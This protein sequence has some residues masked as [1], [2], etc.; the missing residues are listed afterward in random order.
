MNTK[1]FSI[2]TVLSLFSL[3]FSQPVM[4]AVQQVD[5][6]GTDTVAGYET[7][8]RSSK[9]S[10]WQDITFQVMKPDG[11]VLRL[12]S[13]SGVDGVAKVT[14]SDYHTRKAGL[15]S[16]RAGLGLHTD[17][18]SGNF[19]TFRV[20]PDK[21]SSEGS[22]AVLDRTV[23]QSGSGDSAKLTV[24]LADVYGNPVND[25]LVQVF[26]N[27][28]GTGD[29]VTG[30][31]LN[32]LSDLSGKAEFRL[33]SKTKG[34]SDYTVLD[35][36]SG[37]MLNQNVSVAFV[38]G[39]GLMADAGGEFPFFIDIAKAAGPLHHFEIG[40][41]PATIQPNQSVSF[42]VTAKDETNETVQNYTGQIHFSAEG[43]NSANVTLP[44][45][46]TF[47]AE[48][49]GT[50]QFSLGLSFQ[51]AGDY[52]IVATDLTNTLIKGTKD[53]AVGGGGGQ[54]QQGGTETITLDTPV[55]GTYSQSTQ[56]VSGNAQAGLTVKIY[57]NQQEIGSV[58]ATSDGK[59]SFQTSPL[60]DGLHSIYAVMYD[61]TQ[62]AKGTS[63]TVEITIDTT[64]PSV[65]E[66]I[67]DP[68]S[69]IVPGTPINV[70]VISEA[71]LSQA[72][73]VFNGDIIELNPSLEN[74]DTY[75]G[76][77]QAPETPGVYPID[78]LLVDQLSNEGSFK[79]KASVTVS[80]E[81][82]TVE[83]PETQ[84]TQEEVSTQETQEVQPPAAPVNNPPTKVSGLLTYAGNQ[85]V[86]LVWDAAAD[87]ETYVKNYRIYYGV[88]AGN[89]DRYV[90]TK[91]A[92]TTWYV[93]ALENGKEYYFAITA[94]DTEG[95][96]STTLSEIVTGIPFTT[97]VASLPPVGG[98][99]D[100]TDL[101]P[102]AAEFVPPPTTTES[103]PELIWLLMGSASLAGAARRF[104]R[105]IR[106]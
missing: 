41:L 58:Q 34:V 88:D 80:N 10:P 59:Y 96:E 35:A 86:T 77:I 72:A 3:F 63:N 53:V 64:G 36:T 28:S 101:R 17:V 4:A 74:A 61:N 24:W 1:R 92:S 29:S 76:T 71:N 66:I 56:T 26:S 8:L 18:T 103:G 42:S 70:K 39:T 57:D 90:D 9:L 2:L 87:T 65:D 97:E 99:L 93:P 83:T 67:L 16:V 33:S 54:T 7:L 11:T 46:Y 55:T 98:Q 27:R 81:G 62:T 31:S 40:G 30:L 32:G 60:S 47:K 14:L 84:Q 21:V 48:D 68:T 75:V 50:H 78:V 95:V 52:K 15:Y 104:R 89:L 69:G 82:G 44:E 85:K 12:N 45:D 23:V 105:K 102:A 13:N 91:D 6:Y 106:K 19:H 73:I 100:T 25:H 38:S 49:L 37:T 79:E 22:K 5:A 43:A 20:F 51:A 94:F